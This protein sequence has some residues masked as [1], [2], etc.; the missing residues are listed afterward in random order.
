MAMNPTLASVKVAVVGAS[1]GGLAAANVLQQVGASVKV[2]EKSSSGFGQRGE[3]IG[4]V[5]VEMW[6]ELRGV[7]MMRRGR[8]AHRSQGAFFYGDLW[9][10]LYSGLAAGTVDFG[11]TVHDLGDDV[12]RPTIDGT[13]YDLVILADGGWS[14]LR[15]YVTSTRPQYAGYVSW[16][17]C[18]DARAVPGMQSFGI[19]KNEH[20]DTIVLPM[21]KDEGTD[22]LLGG[23]F[24]PTPEAEVV[25]PQDGVSRHEEASTNHQA[26]PEWFLPL[27]RQTFSSH[28]GGELVRLFEAIATQGKLVPH[29]QYDYCAD[30]LC[31]GRVLLVGDAAHMASPRTAAGAHTAVLDAMNLRAAFGAT[32]SVVDALEVY[33]P[34]A[35]Q[36]AMDLH[37]RSLE[38]KR[39]MMP[40]NG[41]AAIQS[42]SKLIRAAAQ[43]V[44]SVQ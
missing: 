28:A 20:L 40:A 25:L 41:M 30:K 16:R 26:P 10:F 15:R 8:R 6:Q 13:A 14:K 22:F 35:L 44:V 18:I 21:C 36:R 39:E 1:L 42:P 38:V 37:R 31:N 29:P 3:G 32:Q 11:H 12:Q 4:F 2:F 27:Y 5:D 43:G 24:V 34:S 9:Q 23:A 19:Y 17:G 7:P 33:I